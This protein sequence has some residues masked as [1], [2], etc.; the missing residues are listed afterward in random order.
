VMGGTIYGVD[1]EKVPVSASYPTGYRYT[2][3][4]LGAE[5][6]VRWKEAMYYFPFNTEDTYKMKNFVANEV[7]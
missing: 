1:I 2:R 7:W 5:R 6:Q 4:R 3:V